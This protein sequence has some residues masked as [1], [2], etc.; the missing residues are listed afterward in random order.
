VSSL[1]RKNAAEWVMWIAL[2]PAVMIVRLFRKE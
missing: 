1:H 2:W